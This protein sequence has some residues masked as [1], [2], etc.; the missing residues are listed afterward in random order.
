MK[1]VKGTIWHLASPLGIRDR[2]LYFHL[3]TMDMHNMH[4]HNMRTICTQHSA[5]AHCAYTAEPL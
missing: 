1:L 5:C 2:I 3:F 4:T